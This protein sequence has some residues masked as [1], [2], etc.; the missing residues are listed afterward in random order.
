MQQ[1]IGKMARMMYRPM[2]AMG[3]ML[4]VIAFVIGYLNSQTAAGY[5][6]QSKVI[7]ETTLMA[8]RAAFESTDQWLPYFKFLGFGLLLGGIVM[9]LRVIVDNLVGAG[10]EVMSNL[11]EEKR[12]QEPAP[13]WYGML[14]PVVMML[15]EVIFIVALVI[16]IQMAGVARA[17]FSNPLPAIDA[18]GAGSVLLAQVQTLHATSAWLIPFKFFGVAT[19]FLAITMGL[20][21]I[22]YILLAQTQMLDQGVKTVRAGMAKGK[23]IPLEPKVKKVEKLAA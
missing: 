6:A 7:R 8:Q 14:M 3:F 10:R 12:P 13:P 9:A 11:P 2:I 15:G 16:S 23:V 1:S 18:A 20:G 19:E 5:F 17:L 4:V 21:T 22:I